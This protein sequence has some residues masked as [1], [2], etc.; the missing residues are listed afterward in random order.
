MQ[1]TFLCSPVFSLAIYL[2][3]L[4]DYYHYHFKGLHRAFT[5]TSIIYRDAVP[6]VA[7][8]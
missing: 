2:S 6:E 8:Y 5:I 1:G 4:K 7:S 3:Y